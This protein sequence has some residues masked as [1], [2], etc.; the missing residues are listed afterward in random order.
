MTSADAVRDA[1]LAHLGAVLD[2]AVVETKPFAHF[3]LEGVFPDVIYAR[4]LESMPGPGL[5]RSLSDKHVLEDGT[6]TRD[7]LQLDDDAVGEMD[8]ESRPLWRG[9]AEALRSPQLKR[10]IFALFRGPLAKRFKVSPADAEDIDGFPNPALIRDLGGYEISPHPDSPSKVV[11]THYYLPRDATQEGLGTAL[12]ELRILQLKNLISPRNALVKVKQFP[13]RPNSMYG[14]AVTRTS[15]HGRELVP[16]A[17]EARN[18][19]LN[20]YY[21]APGKGY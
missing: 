6:S 9:V 4:M 5:Y 21:D 15:W 14:F 11:T 2:A 16:L 3:Y 7:V 10:E 1:V 12:Y 8:D 19:I 17:S 20:I 13:F 18:T